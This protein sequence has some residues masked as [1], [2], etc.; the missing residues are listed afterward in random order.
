MDFFTW[1]ENS[2]FVGWL[3][4]TSWVYPWVI[5]FH[6]I[7]MGFLVGIVFMISLRVLGFGTFSIAPLERY[8]LLVRIAFAV[9]LTTGLLLFVLD[10]RQF[11]SSPT[12]LTKMALIVIGGA[13]G[14]A[15]SKA[16]FGD[17]QPGAAG[18][19]APGRVKVLAAV[20]LLCWVAAIF[21]GRM[22]AYLP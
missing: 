12:F 15:L 20:S 9:S 14:I 5:S 19:D 7:S 21:A 13:T 4:T 17:A 10:A 11:I 2:A 8:L 16:A 6:S 1:L 3:L 22:T 18:G